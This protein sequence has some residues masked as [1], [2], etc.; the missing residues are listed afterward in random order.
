MAS[1]IRQLNNLTQVVL[2]GEHSLDDGLTALERW[3]SKNAGELHEDERRLFSA[4]LDAETTND[5][6]SL[7]DSILK[8]HA[9][10][11]LHRYDSQRAEA[12]LAAEEG[13]PSNAYQV[14][15]KTFGDALNRSEQQ[16]N[17]ARID[18]A[19]ANA[20]QLL[21]DTQGNRRWLE[22]ALNRLPDLAEIDFTGLAQQ[23]P[24]MEPPRLNPFQR[25]GL[26]VI[27]FNFTKLAEQN[28][29][30]LLTLSQ[31][32]AN[33]IIIVAHLI[34]ISL[35]TIQERQRA[36]RAFRIAAHV[37]VRQN[38]MPNQEVGPL[39]DIAEALFPA[40]L[41]ASAILA[42]QA[43]ALSK[44]TGDAESYI[45]ADSLISRIPAG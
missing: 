13:E 4:S 1:L 2:S 25:F 19:I 35:Q 29:T 31:M 26:K 36:R 23:I 32:Q 18:I 24:L 30:D 20:H 21:G 22:T 40:E 9:A 39:L 12:V 41:E 3:L 10:R 7:I 33:Q 17:E 34:G 11:L 5:N 8:M 28:Q 38:G 43:A 42:R 27:G 44:T 15:R 45:R 16:I 6:R 37:I 14:A